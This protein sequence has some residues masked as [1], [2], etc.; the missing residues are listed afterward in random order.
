MLGSVQSLQL[1]QPQRGQRC[2]ACHCKPT[3]PPLPRLSCA[4]ATNH[5]RWRRCC[6]RGMHAQLVALQRLV[7]LLD[8]PL[9]AHL[10]ACDCLNFYCEWRGAWGGVQGPLELWPA[11]GVQS[12]LRCPMLDEQHLPRPA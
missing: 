5:R 8:P 12:K 10:E 3:A 6:C 11:C 4:L 9:Y 2:A 7:Q 1:P